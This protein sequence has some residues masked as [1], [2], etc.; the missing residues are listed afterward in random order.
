MND[1]LS[2]LPPYAKGPEPELPPPRTDWGTALWVAAVVLLFG[3]VAAV[4]HWFILPGLWV[5]AF[6]PELLSVILVG[7]ALCVFALSLVF[8]FVWQRSERQDR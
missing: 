7:L 2:T 8:F 3:G 5:F 1:K 4:V 6:A